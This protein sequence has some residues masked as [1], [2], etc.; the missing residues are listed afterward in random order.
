[1]DEVKS[2]EMVDELTTI[3]T[4]LQENWGKFKEL[5]GNEHNGVWF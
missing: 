5:L 1:M 3:S 4:K 2:R